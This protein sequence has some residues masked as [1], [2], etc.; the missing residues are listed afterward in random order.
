MKSTNQISFLEEILGKPKDKSD[1]LPWEKDSNGVFKG[2][3][4]YLLEEISVLDEASYKE[5]WMQ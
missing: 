5:I 1:L 4:G 3:D 2:A